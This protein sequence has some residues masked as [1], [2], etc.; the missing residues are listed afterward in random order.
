MVGKVWAGVAVM[1][2]AGLVLSSTSPV[3]A[4]D[5]TPLEAELQIVASVNAERSAYGLGELRRL[6]VIDGVARDWSAAMAGSEVVGPDGRP[7]WAAYYHNPDYETQVGAAVP[8]AWV[9]ENIAIR[10]ASGS[11]GDQLAE[12]WLGSPTHRSRVL[13]PNF[14][15]VGVGVVKSS[16]G[17]AYATQNLVRPLGE[18]L[19]SNAPAPVGVTVGEV[20]ETSATVSWSRVTG[21][22]SYAV[23]VQAGVSGT[24]T[25]QKV[26]VD[27]SSTSAR[28]SGLAL[29]SRY[30]A[31]VQTVTAAGPDRVSDLVEFSTRKGVFA[32]T[33][34]PRITG[35]PLAGE[36]LRV[37][38]GI[39]SPTPELTFQWL[40]DG[41]PVPGANAATY[42]VRE[43]DLDRRISVTVTG[44]K[45]GYE[46]VSLTS[47]RT[48]AVRLR[49]LRG[50]GAVNVRGEVLSGGLL[51][52]DVGQWTPVPAFAYQWRRDGQSIAGAT[53][54]EYTLTAADVG[55]QMSVRVTASLTNYETAVLVSQPTAPVVLRQFA[56]VPTVAVVGAAT[57][58]SRLSAQ[59]GDWEP[60]AELSWQWYRAGRA[61]P[62]ASGP[63]YTLTAEDVGTAVS[64]SVTARREH[65]VPVKVNSEATPTVGWRAFAHPDAVGVSGTAR[66]GQRLTAVVGL[67]NPDP[68]F[69]Y[70]WL[71]AGQAV[72]G[73]DGSTYVLTS[74]DAGKRI[75]VRVTASR[76][77]HRSITLTS[78][79]T[80]PVLKRVFG[81]SP[82]PRIVGSPVVGSRLTVKPGVWKP[83]ATKLSFQWYRGGKKIK[84][85][86]KRTYVVSPADLGTK[87]TVKVT[88]RLS[89]YKTVTRPS[90]ATVKV[91]SVR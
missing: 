87:V 66:I 55:A 17:Y 78:D 11:Y 9:G 77:E 6:Q 38:V 50:P 40:R 10:Y 86:T 25:V 27:G 61:I 7:I 42:T 14:T 12:M 5:A 60:A 74:Q 24:T 56:A 63:A 90:R 70:Q 82:R 57:V 18:G 8:F 39:W 64:V 76:E 52:A 36:V 85:A 47:D 32:T 75:S 73:A 1:A 13:F 59:I 69:A 41:Q 53:G 44:T 20:K 80:G 49:G 48:S 21:A 71:R 29:G 35:S 65:H 45:D 91:R 30:F 15:Q 19:G 67:W 43:A 31:T 4:A 54:D 68:S 79:Q 26:L 23:Y 83:K 16:S 58:G 51:R 72:P 34:V 33:T 88:G 81:K 46:P 3:A 89:D 37:D 28:V 2:T 62:G 22:A 84:G